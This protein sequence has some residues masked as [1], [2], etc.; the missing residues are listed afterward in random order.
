MTRGLEADAW[1]DA[2]TEQALRLYRRYELEI[3]AALNLCPWA[4]KARLEG[5]VRE[6]VLLQT[7]DASVEPSL[8][9]IRDADSARDAPTAAPEVDVALL[10][11][12][13]LQIG[14]VDF[15]DFA[16]R[17]RDAEA[18]RHELGRVPFVSAVF[19]PHATPDRSQPERLI[20]FLRRTPDP[21]IQL[22][23]ASILERVRERAPQGTQ[24]VDLA[25]LDTSASNNG[26]VTLRERI[27][28]SNLMTVERIGIAE[29]TRRLD[30]IQRD[31]DISYRALATDPRER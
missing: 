25:S 14:R 29:L 13:C 18:A 15:D 3:V 5:R 22:V 19:H 23:R 20:P 26:D 10:I 9:A 4:E 28:R 27:A 21:T 8:L 2:W 7:D 12:P 11:Y 31:R 16:A 6:H 24:F 1:T 30:E 17:I